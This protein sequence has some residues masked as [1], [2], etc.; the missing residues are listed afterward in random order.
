[1]EHDG[2]SYPEAIR[3]LAKKYN[4]EIIETQDKTFNQRMKMTRINLYIIRLCSKKSKD[5]LINNENILKYLSERKLDKTIIEKF[6]LG[7]LPKGSKEFYDKLIKKG[8][9]RNLN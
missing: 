5:Y 2:C 6:N 8:F 3:Y 9:K 4:V 1:M 7:Y